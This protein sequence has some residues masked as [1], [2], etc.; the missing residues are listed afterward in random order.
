MLL[1]SDGS[2]LKVASSFI[3]PVKIGAEYIPTLRIS[4][5]KSLCTYNFS[6]EIVFILW[7]TIFS[8]W[9]LPSTFDSLYDIS[10]YGIER[11]IPSIYR[12]LPAA[13]LICPIAF[14]Y[15]HSS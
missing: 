10:V 9:D 7:L 11:V 8:T 13:S 12:P 2:H 6:G 14:L 15:R 5:V 4:V 1:S 3:V